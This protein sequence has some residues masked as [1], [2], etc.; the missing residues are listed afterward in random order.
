MP[1]DPIV[2]Y[3]RLVED[4]ER[5]AA[6]IPPERLDPVLWYEIKEAKKELS[7]LQGQT[8]TKADA[9]G[10]TLVAAIRKC[11]RCGKTITTTISKGCK[12]IRGVS[13]SY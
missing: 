10:L 7:K 8:Q 4:L 11:Y 12:H 9:D 2:F 1:R 3:T 5:I 13:D 6:T